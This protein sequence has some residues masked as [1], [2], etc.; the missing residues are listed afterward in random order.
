MKYPQ[1]I[2]SGGQTGV[3]RAGLDAAIEAGLPVG[4][5]VPKGRLAEDVKVPDKY[6]MIETGSRKL[7]GSDKTKCSRIRRYFDNQHWPNGQRYGIDCQDSPG[8]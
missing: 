5:Y 4:G 6:P 2:V 1:R 7:H 8:A 3:D